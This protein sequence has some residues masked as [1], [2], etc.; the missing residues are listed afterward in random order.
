MKS[1]HNRNRN[2]YSSNVKKGIYIPKML[3]SSIYNINDIKKNSINTEYISIDNSIKHNTIKNLKKD[4]SFQTK[5][6]LN[7]FKNIIKQTETLKKRIKGNHKHHLSINYNLVNNKLNENINNINKK[8]YNNKGYNYDYFLDSNPILNYNKSS[9][10]IIKNSKP[11]PLRYILIDNEKKNIKLINKNLTESNVDLINQNNEL[12]KKIYKYYKKKNKI[13]YNQQTLNYYDQNLKKFINN[14]KLCSQKNI[15]EN[16][17]LTKKIL[18]NLKEIQSIYN[19]YNMNNDIYKNSSKKLIKDINKIEKDQN[20]NNDYK[21]LY[22]L[23][24]EQN[25]LN[26]ELGKLKN[27]LNDLKLIEK[28]LSIKYE[29]ELK[30]KQ[31]FEELVYNL[32]NT[33]KNLK[34]EKKSFNRVSSIKNIDKSNSYSLNNSYSLDIY[35]S[36]INQLNSII[37]SIENQKIILY[38]ENFKLKKEKKELNIDKTNKKEIIKENDLKKQLEDLK[39]ETNTKKNNL[40]KKDN[41]IKILKNIIKKLSKSIKDNN[42]NT[43]NLNINIEVLT[44]EDTQDIEFEN[45][46]NENNLEEDIKKSLILNEMKLKEISNMTKTYE[47]LINEKDKEIRLLESKT[48]NKSGLIKTIEDKVKPLYKKNIISKD[49]IFTH[50][51]KNN[52]NITSGQITIKISKNINNNIILNS[53]KNIHDIDN[54]YDYIIN[55]ILKKNLKEKNFINKSNNFKKDKYIPFT[56]SKKIISNKYIKQIYNN[57]NYFEQFRCLK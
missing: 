4:I 14:L 41:Q 3:T 44:K 23:K 49:N 28:N 33:I 27:N 38:E 52:S 39:N 31:D 30:S 2:K 57:H 7:D 11:L 40:Q 10:N 22:N 50:I 36:K 42:I 45:I 47:N 25:K 9:N 53:Q 35:E 5:K 43:K 20:Y 21:K 19:K 17:Q 54:K 26:K 34:N 51:K 24:D 13:Q 32:N 37:K 1:F 6:I 46:L 8:E 12:E 56:N 48:Y 18:D 16:L 55:K 15:N 29:T